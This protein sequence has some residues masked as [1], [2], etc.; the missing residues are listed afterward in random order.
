MKQRFPRK[1]AMLGLCLAL[2]AGL[3]QANETDGVKIG[4]LTDMA[5]VTAD[6]TGKGSVE[7]ARLAIE[8]IPEGE[9]VCECFGVT[10]TQ[11]LKAIA[12]N[13]LLT[14]EDVTSYTKAGGGC[15]R[16]APTIEAILAE[17]KSGKPAPKPAPHAADAAKPKLTNIQRMTL[18][19]KTIDE[20]VRPHLQADGGDIALIDIDGPRV[21]VSL[22]GRCAGCHSGEL[23]LRNL[24][25]ARLRDAVDDAIR[26]EEVK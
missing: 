26:V 22:R 9:L 8:E 1:R 3:A 12:A 20:E 5:G 11:I 15:G 24:V 2:A 25:E 21:L 7:A 6:A 14:A 19:Q 16:C 17:V 18:I 4:V 10:R 23:T 13:N